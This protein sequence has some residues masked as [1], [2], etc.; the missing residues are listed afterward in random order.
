VAH[1]LSVA[2]LFLLATSLYHRTQTFDML[3]MGG[4]VQKAPV[5]AAFFTVAMLASIAVPAGS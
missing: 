5:L 3:S 4:L 2:L 1:G